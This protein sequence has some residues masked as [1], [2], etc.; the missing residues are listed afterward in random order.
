[1]STTKIWCSTTNNFVSKKNSDA[2]QK[3]IWFRQ[4][5]NNVAWKNVS[6]QQKQVDL[7]QKKYFMCSKTRRYCTIFCSQKIN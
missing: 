6:C 7:A 4:K 1:M 2:A 5:Q 3:V